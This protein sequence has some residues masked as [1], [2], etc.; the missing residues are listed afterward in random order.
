MTV[1]V[2]PNSY[3]FQQTIQYIWPK[4]VPDVLN[5]CQVVLTMYQPFSIMFSRALAAIQEHFLFSLP[6]KEEGKVHIRPK[7]ELDRE[8]IKCVQYT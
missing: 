7:Q 5:V 2:V 3:L 6:F 8:V 4:T 1:V